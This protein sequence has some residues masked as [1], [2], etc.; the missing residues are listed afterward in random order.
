MDVIGLPICSNLGL[1]SNGLKDWEG[2]RR[3]AQRGLSAQA[4]PVLECVAG[5]LS[6][7]IFPWF[8]HG[9]TTRVS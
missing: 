5:G 2:E 3:F 1:A 6:A 7:T 4:L 9:S 8:R